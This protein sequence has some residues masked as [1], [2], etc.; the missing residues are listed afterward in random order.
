MCHF[1]FIFIFIIFLGAQAAE[2]WRVYNAF[3]R[4]H[5]RGSPLALQRLHELLH[6]YGNASATGVINKRRRWDFPGSF[7][8]VGTIVS[9][10]GKKHNAIPY[11]ECRQLLIHNC[12]VTGGI[13]VSGN[14][15]ARST[16]YIPMISLGREVTEKS[17]STETS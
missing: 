17:I 15:V 10:I 6:A 14:R 2:F 1:V 7:H 4:H 8:F 12:I 16:L 11:L 9:T 13:G 5:L 3:R